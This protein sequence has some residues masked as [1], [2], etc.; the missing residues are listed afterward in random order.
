MVR[1]IWLILCCVVLFRVCFV[2]VCFVFL[3]RFSLQDA[4]VIG[5]RP[6]SPRAE[7][8]VSPRHNLRPTTA[9]AKPAAS[10]VAVPEM[11]RREVTESNGEIGEEAQ[12]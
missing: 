2:L 4:S 6:K 1:F 11:R 10:A 5:S 3:I 9:S 7:K 12:M 8:V